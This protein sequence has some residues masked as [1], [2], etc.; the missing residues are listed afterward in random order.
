MGSKKKISIGSFKYFEQT[1]NENTTYQH[2]WDA[3]KAVFIKG[4]VRLAYQTEVAVGW[5]G[6]R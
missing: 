5:L 4:G 6:T 2:L 1:E 3:V